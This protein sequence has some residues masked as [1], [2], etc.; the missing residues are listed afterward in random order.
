MAVT[1]KDI[2][3]IAGVNHSTVSRSLND[4]PLISAE[5]KERIKRIA[6]ELG[7]EF[8]S[9]ARGLSTKKTG[10]IGLVY[11][12]GFENFNTNLFFSSIQRHVR[13]TV[14][15]EDYDVIVTFPKNRY[16]GGD[17]IQ[18]LISRKKVDGLIIVHPDI[19]DQDL[20]YLTDTGIPFVF[21]HK[22]PASDLGKNIDFYCTDHFKGGYLAAK[23]LLNAGRKR[24]LC[25]SYDIDEFHMRTEGYKK[26][27]EEQRI[28]Y[29][30]KLVFYGDCSFES[31][32]EAINNHMDIVKTVDGIFAQSDLMAYGAIEALRKNHIEVPEHVAVVGYDD[33]ELGALLSPKLTTIHQPRE[34]LVVMACQRLIEL[35]R[36]DQKAGG[37]EKVLEPFLVIRESCGL[38]K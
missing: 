12:E 24:I 9:N 23:H 29:D 34:E 37:T 10:T 17:N 5:T 28:P 1:I 14:E 4:S 32:F 7:F 36:E 18:K 19:E 6:E 8:N 21:L 16:T 27:L 2:A 13:Q 20:K 22:K 3:K 33:I 25:I 35:I 11:P 38:K 26:A 31:A 15:R 30:E